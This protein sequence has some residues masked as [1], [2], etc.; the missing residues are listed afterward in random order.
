MASLISRV[1]YKGLVAE[2][3]VDNIEADI[4]DSGLIVGVKET[5]VPY[6]KDKN[7]IL[8]LTDFHNFDNMA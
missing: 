4:L 3:A 1:I 6:N 2:F 8:E 5:R 7:L